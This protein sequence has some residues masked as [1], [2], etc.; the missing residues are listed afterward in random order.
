ME[1]LG[2]GDSL[3]DDLFIKL[4]REIRNFI[5]HQ[6]VLSITNKVRYWKED[7]GQIHY[8]SQVTTS[9]ENI[10]QYL[11]NE[12][13]K[14]KSLIEYFEKKSYEIIPLSE[15][16][17]DLKNVL[18]SNFASL[19]KQF[20]NENKKSLIILEEKYKDIYQMIIESDMSH[21]KAVGIKYRYLRLLLFVYSETNNT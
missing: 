15:I 18:E 20:V 11:E 8:K 10:K 9:C 5:L 3:K 14:M 21:Y 7:D 1:N 6:E 17:F 13:S 12:K 19:K 16:I 2:F 4:T